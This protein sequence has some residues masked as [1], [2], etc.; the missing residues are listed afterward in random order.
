MSKQL[1]AQYQGYLNTPNLWF[2]NLV[3]KLQQLELVSNQPSTS[4]QES[5]PENI[6]LGKRVE[7]FVF[8]QLKQVPQISMVFENLQIQQ[9]K[10]TLG[11]MD[12]L[13]LMDNKPV[14][15]EI[16]YKFYVYDASGGTSELDCW[17][18]PN[19]KD[20]LVQKLDKLKN[21]QLPLLYHPETLKY[22]KKHDIQ[23]DNIQQ[24]VLFKAQLFLPYNLKNIESKL[25]ND[26]CIIGFYL[27]KTELS[28]IKDCKCYMPTKEN[29]LQNPHPQVAWSTYTSFIEKV[30]PVLENQTSPLV[31]IKYPNGELKKCFLVWW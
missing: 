20:S 6:R 26:A 27:K 3:Y 28:L 4:F 13:L 18:G 16:I 10:H 8:Y 17:I 29:W 12:A 15:L 31:W 5:L 24:Q 19:Q 14:H 23:V 9:E 2:G 21:K 1:N 22:L 30:I 7:Q 25:I 11:E